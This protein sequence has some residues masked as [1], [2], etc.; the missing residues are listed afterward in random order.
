MV[1]T[2]EG[3]NSVAGGPEHRRVLLG[4]HVTVQAVALMLASLVLTAVV[5]LAVLSWLENMA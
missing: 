4:V 3:L 2:I 1:R 5:G